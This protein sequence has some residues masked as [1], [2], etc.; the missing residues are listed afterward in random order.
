MQITGI[1]TGRPAEWLLILSIA[2]FLMASVVLLL[3]IIQSR[4]ARNRK[5]K[6]SAEYALVIEQALMEVLFQDRE[7]AHLIA[8]RSFKNL[9]KKHQF[10]QQLIDS[11]INLHRNY[12]GVYARRLEQLYTDSPLASCSL[13]KLSRLDWS[14]RCKGMEELAEMNMA[15]AFPA[16]T[17]LSATGNSTV[18]ITALNA[19][20]KLN[21]TRGILHLADQQQPLDAWTRLNIVNAIRHSGAEE[22]QGIDKLL[23]STN[24]TVVSLGLNL[25]ES[26]SLIAYVPAVERFIRRGDFPLLQAAAQQTLNKITSNMEQV[27]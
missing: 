20:I 24:E 1:F 7:Y 14:L 18:R 10:R 2:V 19:C 4:A 3:M 16:L 13:R 17:K 5:E 9:L 23:E 11:I 27:A 12:D 6:H 22:L 15:E 26:F 8:D 25:V 21:G